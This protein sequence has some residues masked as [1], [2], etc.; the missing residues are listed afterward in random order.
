[1]TKSIKINSTFFRW[2]TLGIQI[3]RRCKIL[4]TWRNGSLT[5][6]KWDKA[7]LSPDSPPPKINSMHPRLAFPMVAIIG[8]WMTLGNSCKITKTISYRPLSS[9]E[10]QI[11]LSKA[12]SNRII[13]K[14]GSSRQIL[15][16]HNRR[17]LYT[18]T[19]T[20]TNLVEK[21]RCSPPWRLRCLHKFK[22]LRIGW[23][24]K[25]RF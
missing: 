16:T 15:S 2:A 11:T 12:W 23:T 8:L 17:H 5:L 24:Q 10:G 14:T 20:K 22:P 18:K 1:M 3:T 13:I 21:L 25:S 9:K 7:L 19:K 6:T 4:S